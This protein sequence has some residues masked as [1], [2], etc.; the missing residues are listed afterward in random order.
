M[1]I[2]KIKEFINR[3][4]GFDISHGNYD[5]SN[6]RNEKVFCR[7]FLIYLSYKYSS[8]YITNEKIGK[9]VKITPASVLHG[10]KEFDNLIRYDKNESRNFKILEDAF[11][12]EFNPDTKELLEIIE[13]KDLSNLKKIRNLKIKLDKSNNEKNK[14]INQLKKAS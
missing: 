14:L 9:S 8:E 13:T 1:T 6:R 11:I 5:F 2:K 12:K 10:I 4:V 3:E 7:W